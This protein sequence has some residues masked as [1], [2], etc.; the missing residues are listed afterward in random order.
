MSVDAHDG[1]GDI[2]A[3]YDRVASHYGH[4]GP[5]VFSYFGRRLVDAT[6]VMRGARVLD[7]AAGRGAILFPAAVE[8]TDEGRVIGID[9]A[10][11]MVQ[12]TATEI[13]RKGLSNAEMLQM[14]AE[15]LAFPDASF[16]AVF[17]GFAI[18]FLDIDRALS[19]FYRVL[20]AGGRLGVNSG[21]GLD[22]RWQWYNDLL[23]AYHDAYQIPL[24]PPR[25]GAPWRPSDL[26]GVLSHAGFVDVRV[27]VD[28]AEFIYADEQE[29]WSAK[30][31]HGARYPLERMQPEVLAQFKAEAFARL[32][33]LKQPDGFHEHWRVLAVV[34][35]KSGHVT[36]TNSGNN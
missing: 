18:F 34:G 13:R 7:V 9:V 24:G 1:G 10:E 20:R 33:P 29:W 15:R 23:V 30:W 35:M 21:N 26:P 2:G 19:E 4:V 12:E 27:T 3:L 11:A 8:A 22:E 28:D 6:G 16:D 31:T 36:S 14:D 5:A 25:R 17:C 32:A